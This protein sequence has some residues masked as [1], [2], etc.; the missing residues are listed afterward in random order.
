MLV[1]N[2]L[3]A[4]SGLVGLLA[5]L[6][7][8]VPAQAKTIKLDCL[9][10]GKVKVLDKEKPEAGV[11]KIGGHGDYTFLGRFNCAG[12]EK[13]IPVI[14]TF[15]V[16]SEGYYANVVCVPPAIGKAISTWEKNN[17]IEAGSFA[18]V[19]GD[20]AKDFN[21]A[22]ALT[23]ELK[24][25]VEFTPLG[26]FLWHNDGTGPEVKED[27]SHKDL[28]AVKPLSDTKSEWNAPEDKNY[29]N[30]GVVQLLDSLS[31]PPKEMKDDPPDKTKCARG[32][33]VVGNIVI[34]L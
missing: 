16:H 20:P 6:A 27:S 5:A 13:G 9:F 32:F 3:L 10:V 30:G 25:A 17:Y 14:A 33:E 18:K 22:N 19:G 34:D 29:V 8:A 12:V 7:F 23:G 28:P 21:F 2:R 4:L 26:I 1:F 11:R 24:Y 31:K 15:A